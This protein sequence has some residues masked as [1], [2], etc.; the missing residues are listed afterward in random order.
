[1]NKNIKIKVCLVR[2][3]FNSLITLSF[4]SFLIFMCKA[5]NST[6]KS[7]KVRMVPYNRENSFHNISSSC[8]LCKKALVLYLIYQKLM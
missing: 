5:L 4:P 8:N 7:P 3:R 1:M 6:I 2:K